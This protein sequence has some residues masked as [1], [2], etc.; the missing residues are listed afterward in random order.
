VRLKF[1]KGFTPEAIASIFLQVIEERG[2]VI[3][4]VNIYF[5]EYDANMKP[6][7]QEEEYLEA[8]P[9]EDS[10]GM[11]SDYVADLRRSKLKAI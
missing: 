11:Y 1:K 6:I 3:G 7:K 8:H 10:V 2:N 5:Q 9:G 4:A